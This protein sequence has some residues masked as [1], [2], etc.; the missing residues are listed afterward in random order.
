[1]IARIAA[2]LWL[3]LAGCGERL[4]RD[5]ERTTAR[6]AEAGVL[7][8][9]VTEQPPW[10]VKRDGRPAGIEAALIERFAA[11]RRAQIAWVWG[12][13]EALF[14]QLARFEL[15]LVIGGI[16]EETEWSERI[17]LT[18]TRSDVADAAPVIAVPPGENGWLGEVE[19]F[20]KDD[21]ARRPAETR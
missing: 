5:P 6:V 11:A 20:L 10:V 15:D 14:A 3:A 7:R 16:R 12:Q 8:V 19:R 13:Q 2:V 9:G 17:G 21:L 1:M 18:R 4:P